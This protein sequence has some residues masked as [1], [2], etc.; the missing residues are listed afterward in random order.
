MKHHFASSKQS[1]AVEV[2]AQVEVLNK[3]SVLTLVPV[4]AV[5]TEGTYVVQMIR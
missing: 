5:L 4:A 2:E 3:S 1:K